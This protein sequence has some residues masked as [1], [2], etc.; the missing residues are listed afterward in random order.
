[1]EFRNSEKHFSVTR[2]S[3]CS[4]VCLRKKMANSVVNEL[5]MP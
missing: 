3:P 1:M 5:Q 4:T 2:P